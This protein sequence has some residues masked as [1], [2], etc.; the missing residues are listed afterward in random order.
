MP[1]FFI[2]KRS[3]WKYADNS[4][5]D[6]KLGDF[7]AAGISRGQL[8]LLDPT[9]APYVLDYYAGGAGVG[10]GAKIPIKVVGKV[11]GA[12]A[13][14]A[15]RSLIK[16]INHAMEKSD[17][18][19]NAFMAGR[20]GE[21][22]QINAIDNLGASDQ[23]YADF[24]ED[25]SNYIVPEVLRPSG[26]LI[27][28]GAK[29]TSEDLQPSDFSGLFYYTNLDARICYGLSGSGFFLG[30]DPSIR[31]RLNRMLT[32]MTP[33]LNSS[34]SF[35]TKLTARLVAGFQTEALVADYAM[36]L[37]GNAKAFL[38]FVGLS[39]DL[40]AGAAAMGYFGSGRCRPERPAIPQAHEPIDPRDYEGPGAYPSWL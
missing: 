2:R 1:T 5:D 19:R 39:L 24:D 34:G 7:A 18:V 28:V 20:G 26:G 30:L 21:R 12:A 36:E 37:L 15:S 9:G 27:F 10:V 14:K 29:C 13:A 38:F 33:R 40:G 25:W 6:A 16:K 32:E 3:G 22:A 17:D 8:R 23:E 11:M 4:G 35:I 31:P